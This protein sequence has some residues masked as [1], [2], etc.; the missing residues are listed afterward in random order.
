MTE[1]NLQ[2][3]KIRCSQVFWSYR[4]N[5]Y[6]YTNFRVKP[7]GTRKEVRVCTDGVLK[8]SFETGVNLQFRLPQSHE[9]WN[10]S[11]WIESYNED[12]VKGWCTRKEVR[13][14]TVLLLPSKVETGDSSSF[15]LKSNGVKVSIL[16]LMS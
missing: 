7:L 2:S 16:V 11:L 10:Y 3:S 9:I 14:C 4:L 5:I 1:E 12:K 6:D 15:F 8:S 13:I